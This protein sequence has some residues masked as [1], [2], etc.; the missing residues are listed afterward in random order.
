LKCA[1]KVGRALVDSRERVICGAE[2][3]FDKLALLMWTPEEL[4]EFRGVDQ[5]EI[6]ESGD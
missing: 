2:V 5:L 6:A 1:W 4:L 3:R